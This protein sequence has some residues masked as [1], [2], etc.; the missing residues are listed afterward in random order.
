M[1]AKPRPS[2]QQRP[3]PP[4]RT[5]VP[6]N[7]NMSHSNSFHRYRTGHTRS[8]QHPRHPSVHR[9]ARGVI[10]R[11]VA[12]SCL[13]RRHNN[14]PF[15]AAIWRGCCRAGHGCGSTR[16]LPPPCPARGRLYRCRAG[17]DGGQHGQSICRDHCLSAAARCPDRCDGGVGRP[18]SCSAHWTGR[19]GVE[20]DAVVGPFGV[21]REHVPFVVAWQG[22][23]RRTGAAVPLAVAG[24]SRSAKLT[25]LSGVE[26]D[27]IAAS[28][29]IRHN[30]VP[31]AARDRAGVVAKGTGR[32]VDSSFPA[33]APLG[34]G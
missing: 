33:A 11:D 1:S 23:R 17:P 2:I 32:G 8:I 19:G 26:G 22:K 15:S 20:W 12:V 4:G 29:D 16:P 6:L 27:V 24:M 10:E 5:A 30:N 28:L 34:A 13:D 21:C 31:F 3:E 18:M 25:G 9:T 14:V 7:R